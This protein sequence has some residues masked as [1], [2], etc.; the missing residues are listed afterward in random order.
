MK[1][2]SID[3][4]HYRNIIIKMIPFSLNKKKISEKRERH[5]P[6]SFRIYRIIFSFFAKSKLKE[7]GIIEDI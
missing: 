2:N 5:M 7:S 1:E 6:T 4:L 3:M